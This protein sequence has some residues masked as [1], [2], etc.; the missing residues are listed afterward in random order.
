MA[1][2]VNST[3]NPVLGVSAAVSGS[4]LQFG[5]QAKPIDPTD[6]DVDFEEGVRDQI[7]KRIFSESVAGL[8]EETQVVLRNGVEKDGWSDWGDFDVLAPRLAQALREIGSAR[9]K[10][11]VFF[12]EKDNMIGN[13]GSKGCQWLEECWRDLDGV[14]FESRTVEGADHD[15][16][17]DQRWGVMESVFSTMTREAGNGS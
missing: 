4:I 11:D 10:I 17:W 3:I 15:C 13:A 7:V 12:A 9:L 1:R 6:P 5:S 2:F 8:G 14:E 16:V